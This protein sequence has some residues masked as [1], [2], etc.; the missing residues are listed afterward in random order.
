MK[1]I[2]ITPKEIL[3]DNGLKIV[4]ETHGGCRAAFERITKK[5]WD[6]DF[7]RVYFDFNVP[8]GAKGCRFGDKVRKF[9]I[10]CYQKRR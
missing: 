7:E 6:Y 8:E 10:P 5:V 9:Y 2:K 3:F 4:Q 1:I